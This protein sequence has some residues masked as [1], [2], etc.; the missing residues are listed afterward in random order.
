MICGV[1]SGFKKELEIKGVGYKASISGEDLV[2]SLGFSHPIKI[3]PQTGI[4]FSVE[5]NKIIITG[6]NKEK[7]GII[8]SQIRSFRKPE[9]YKGKGIKYIDE[10]I[11]RKAG[12]AGKVTATSS[13]TKQSS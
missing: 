5:K 2:L 13:I 3:K 12:K 1:V 11:K 10:I 9:P 7:V 8:A 6:I 4:K